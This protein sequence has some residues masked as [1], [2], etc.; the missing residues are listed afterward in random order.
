MQKGRRIF[1]I[2]DDE[3]FLMISTVNLKTVCSDV[4]IL[5]ATN[6]QEGLLQL[7]SAQPNVI[8]LDVNMPVMGGWEF[9]EKLSDVGI[10][11]NLDF[12]IY[13]TTSS[14]DPEDKRRAQLHPLVKG[15]I[16]KPLTAEKIREME[17][18]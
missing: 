13:I 2:D 7:N 9:L 15:F 11:V 8:L 1:L 10:G 5:T 17:I 12:P 14:V 4:E 16:E 3:I 18:C 6:G